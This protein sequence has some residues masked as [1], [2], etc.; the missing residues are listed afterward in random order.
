MQKKQWDESI[1]LYRSS[2]INSKK[3]LGETHIFTAEIYKDLA[4]IYIKINMIEEST[5][6]MIKAIEIYEKLN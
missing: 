4:N 5:V 6:N 1:A 3:C 2:L